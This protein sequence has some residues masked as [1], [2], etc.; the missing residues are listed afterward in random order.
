MYSQTSTKEI[1]KM[2]AGRSGIGQS[3]QPVQTRPQDTELI[4]QDENMTKPLT[5]H[6]ENR[7]IRELVARPTWIEAAVFIFY[8]YVLLTGFRYD[9]E[10]K[11]GQ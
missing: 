4:T 10:Y 6:H 8:C 1:C 2:L 9:G 11:T 5:L 3:E 7:I